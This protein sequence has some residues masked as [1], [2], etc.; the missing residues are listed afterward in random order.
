[1]SAI[2]SASSGVSVARAAVA[3]SHCT[4][5]VPAGLVERGAS[6]QFCCT[7]C[8]TAYRVIR[9]GGLSAF[10]DLVKSEP[11]EARRARETRAEYAHFDDPAFQRLYARPVPAGL[12]ATLRVEGVHCAACVWLLER[13]NRVTPGVIDTRVDM[14]RRTLT[15]TWEPSRVRLSD[16]AASAASLGYEVHS[17]RGLSTSDIR[18]KESRA[19]LVRVGVAGAIMG[20]VMLVTLALFASDADTASSMSEGMLRF[21]RVL[22]MAMSL[23]SLAWPGSVF[24]RGAWAALRTRTPSMDVPIAVGLSLGA[25]WGAVNAVRGEGSVYFDTIVTLVFLLLL[26][27][28]IQLTQQHKAADSVE[29]LFSLTPATARVVDGDAVREVPVESLTSGDAGAIVEVVTGAAFPVD[30]VITRGRTRVDLSLLTGESKPVDAGEGDRVTAGSV[31]IDS[32]VRVRVEAAGESTR[33]AQLMRLVEDA[34][35]DKAPIVKL[36]DRVSVI[37]VPVV[38]LLALGTAVAWAFIRPSEAV[39]HAAA[40]LITTCP[41]AL[42]LATPLAVIV[43]I[44]RAA[45]RGI[46]VKGGDTL[47][48]VASPGAR[49]VILLDKTG[50]ITEGGAALVEFAG[51]RSA[52]SAAAAVERM[53]THPIARAIVAAAGS[54]PLPEATG[55]TQTLG[56][57]LEG[58]VAARRVVVGSRAYVRSRCAMWSDQLGDSGEAMA[59]RALTPVYIAVDDRLAGVCGLGDNIRSDA[60]ASVS[61]LQR[62]GW[63]V[64]V[65]SGDDPRLVAGVAERIGL[66]ASSA[67][68]G[69]TPEG[70]LAAVR[71]LLEAVPARTVVMVGDGVNDA[72]ALSAA[73]VGVAVHGSAEASLAAAGVFLSRPGLAPLAELTEGACRTLRVIKRNMAASLLYNALFVGLAV[74]GVLTPLIA[75][76]V[77]PFTSLTVVLLSVRSR[78]FVG[79]GGRG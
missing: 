50:T 39:D 10:Y 71:E 2:E 1:M 78:T 5:P 61:D 11:G 45:R 35:R 43:S 33:V 59:G 21:F 30:G 25:A 12:S 36:A 79:E 38:L 37:F 67:R 56:Q 31:N 46:L 26:G 58:E 18:R 73:T 69:V 53:T 51:D 6:E 47:E 23:V 76:V 60:A 49:G 70:K 32:P 9:A 4:L 55:V 22:A 8:R 66:P 27:R 54:D 52:L 48:A 42:G 74:T 65:L 34:A 75:A 24:F 68:G 7:G 44:G 3:C 41:C 72:A 28:W 57:G 29:V 15:V 77:M 64:R 62:R 63:E 17:P 13:L 40:L 20:N 14:R 16:I 19:H